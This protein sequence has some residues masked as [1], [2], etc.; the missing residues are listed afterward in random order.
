MTDKIKENDITFKRIWTCMVLILVSVFSVAAQVAEAMPS[1]NIVGIV[2]NKKSLALGGFANIVHEDAY[3]VQ[4]GGLYNHIGDMGCGLAVAG[5]ANTTLG[6]YY[7]A[8]IGGLWNYATDAKGLMIGGLN[9]M[10]RGEFDGLQITGLIN[11]VKHNSTR[12]PEGWENAE[13]LAFRHFDVRGMQLAGLVNIAENVCG[14]QFAGLTN[15]AE[16]VNGA[17]FSGLVNTAKDVDGLQFTGLVNVARRVRG[18]QFASI[19]N[20][21]EE[22][23]CP[24][25][26]INIIKEG[27]KGI[28]FTCNMLG[29]SVVSFRS[30]GKYTYGILGVGYNSRGNMYRVVGEA[31]YGIQIPICR[32]LDVNNEFKATALGFSGNNPPR[33]FSYLLAPSITL[34]QHC[35]L[36]GGPSINYWM[37]DASIVEG[38]EPYKELWHKETG[39]GVQRLY[40]GYQ[41]GVQYVL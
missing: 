8:Q 35:N 17:Q 20:V 23:D 24:I 40:I 1:I 26:L 25:G 15:I 36:F 12:L 29:N 14:V 38:M 18:I 22:S 41:V 27:D 16:K 37:S 2:R 28:A 32:W 6:H 4:I 39:K 11:L 3:G 13:F 33:N 5:L 21:A 7:G 34:W 19:L 9:N 10:T 31:G 30:G